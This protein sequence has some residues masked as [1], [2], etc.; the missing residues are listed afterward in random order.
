[1]LNPFKKKI[2]ISEREIDYALAE[3]FKKHKN[4]Q[5]GKIEYK[6]NKSTGRVINAK[7]EIFKGE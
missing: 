4:I 7:A 6:V 5:L 1:M 3:Y 2:T